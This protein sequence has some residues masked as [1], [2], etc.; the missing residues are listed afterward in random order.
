M[1]KKIG[2]MA[3]V[4]IVCAWN[5]G[6]VQVGDVVE[7]Y[8]EEVFSETDRFTVDDVEYLYTFKGIRK[9]Q[10]IVDS[11]D[12][13]GY[14]TYQKCGEKVE[15]YFVIERAIPLTG[16][17]NI[18]IDLRNLFSVFGSTPQHPTLSYDHKGTEFYY[19]AAST[20]VIGDKCF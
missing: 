1:L 11:V 4:A 10:Q 12:D 13:I 20:I 19:E 8:N 2:M 5:A 16:N 17:Y 3:V 18:V 9:C 6:A 7:E 15:T 14:T